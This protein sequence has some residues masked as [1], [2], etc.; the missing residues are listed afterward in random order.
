MRAGRYQR[1]SHCLLLSLRQQRSYCFD[2]AQAHLRRSS[3]GEDAID[4]LFP[5]P[6]VRSCLPHPAKLS[7]ACPNLFAP[8]RMRDVQAFNCYRLLIAWHELSSTVEF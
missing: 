3:G 4:H 6:R 7:Q 1:A 5:Q 2:R 8:R